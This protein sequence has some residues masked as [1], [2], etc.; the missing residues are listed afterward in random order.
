M[1]HLFVYYD[2]QIEMLI[3]SFNIG[4]EDSQIY[5][6][7]IILYE[8]YKILWEKNTDETTLISNIETSQVYKQ[9]LKHDQ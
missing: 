2:F 3:H 5:D 6:K 9:T 1:Q 4:V 7:V 8:Q